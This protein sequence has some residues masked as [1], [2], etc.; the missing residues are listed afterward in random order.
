[1]QGVTRLARSEWTWAKEVV[2]FE[3]AI[4]C[5]AVKDEMKDK[6]PKIKKC[7]E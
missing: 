4:I 2:C 7:M 1:M 3:T 6:D 5:T